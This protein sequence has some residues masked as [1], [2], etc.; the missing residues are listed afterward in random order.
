M[1]SHCETTEGWL[2]PLIDPIARNPNI[3]TIPIVEVIDENT[4]QVYSTPI[5]SIQIGGFNWNLIF[6]WRPVPKYEMERR[7]LTTDPIRSPTMSGGLFAINRKYFEMLGL[8][9]PG[10]D[11]WGGE[12]LELSFRIWMCGGE[13]VC[14]PCSHVGHIFRKWSPYK[15]QSSVNAIL[16][17]NAVRVAEVWLDDYKKYYYER[18]Q[19]E[20]GDFGDVSER[21]ALR[22]RLECKTFEW[23][24]KNVFPEQFVPEES[25][26]YGEVNELF[27]L[28][29]SSF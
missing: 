27:N 26:Y 4:F 25:I 16:K 9:D 12:N 7:L 22:E 18:L 28:K 1:D 19:N 3:S 6:N 5:K 2:E 21:K 29:I 24:L 23:Y 13:L 11:I 14:A 15:W 20:L 10:M 17:K 8:Y